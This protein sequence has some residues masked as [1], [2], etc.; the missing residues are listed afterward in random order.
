MKRRIVL[1]KGSGYKSGKDTAAAFIANELHRGR[2]RLILKGMFAYTVKKLAESLT[3]MKMIDLNTPEQEH[4]IR[5]PF[6]N[7]T[8][9]FS[10]IQKETY[11][12]LWGMTLGRMLQLLATEG[13]RNHF[14]KDIH[15]K[16]E[17]IR[18]NN[19][20]DEYAEGAKDITVII[21]DWRFPNEEQISDYLIGDWDVH[22][23][24]VSRDTSDVDAGSWVGD[25]T[26]RDMMHESESYEMN[27]GHEISNNGS[28]LELAEACSQFVKLIK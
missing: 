27:S 15:V 16:A 20:V 24:E 17:A 12:T 14:D 5:Y 22:L 2:P 19:L 26:G 13:M 28:L 1:I 7:P 21:S 25:N 4:Y 10:Q 11:L 23:V 6:S 9:D 8:P 3:Q 18:I